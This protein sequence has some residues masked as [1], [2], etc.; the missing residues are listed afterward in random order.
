[1][2]QKYEESLDPRDRYGRINLSVRINRT[3]AQTLELMVRFSS[4]DTS[5]T[6]YHSTLSLASQ[7]QFTT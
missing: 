7:L 1:M 4:A 5:A 6:T 3:E 2:Y